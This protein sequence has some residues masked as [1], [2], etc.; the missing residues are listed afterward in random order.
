M[1]EASAWLSRRAMMGAAFA[2]LTAGPWRPA[3]GEIRPAIQSSMADGGSPTPSLI[4]AGPPRSEAADFARLL[5]APLDSS[6]SSEAGAGSGRLT[7][8]FW[9]GQDGV[10]GL[11]QFQARVLPGD[12][13]ALI[14]PG[15]AL[16]ASLIGDPRAAVDGAPLLPML[17][18][19]GPGLL[20]LRGPLRAR[21]GPVRV[22][23]SHLAEPSLAGVLGLDLLQ[24]SAE[25]VAAPGIDAAFQHAVDAVF[26]HGADVPARSMALSA[27]GLSPVF[28]VG[29][30]EAP[31]RD[32]SFAGVPSLPELL[33]H[34]AGATLAPTMSRVWNAVSAA[35]VLD[36]ALAVPAL[37]PSAALARW[38]NACIA[39]AATLGT[40]EAARG[41]ELLTGDPA[42][43][44]ASP[45][46]ID[47]AGQIALRRWAITRLRQQ[48]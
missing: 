4:A 10:T 28:A 12:Q 7:L 19:V 27:A 25:P 11:N 33:G 13:G 44:A 17:A 32:P 24:V 45:I 40:R 31:W 20:M 39:A 8:R 41:L 1:D 2:S 34:S 47:P 48:G 26:L 35:S 6:L 15:S 46:Q 3:M 21:K 37:T 22:A 23:V 30:Q 18:R 5:L 9:G 42:V 29:C 14:Y 16:M 38:R 43:S 36:T